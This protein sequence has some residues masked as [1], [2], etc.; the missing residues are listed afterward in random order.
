MTYWG[1]VEHQTE[2]KMSRN[3]SH[4]FVVHVRQGLGRTFAQQ[5]GKR[6]RA[7]T[8]VLC[9]KE[10]DFPR[11]LDP[12]ET[13]A[14]KTRWRNLCTRLFFPFTTLWGDINSVSKNLL[15]L[16]TDLPAAGSHSTHVVVCAKD[17]LDETTKLNWTSARTRFANCNH[18][19]RSP[20]GS[21]QYF[22]DAGT[23]SRS[24]DETLSLMSN[25]KP[26]NVDSE[27]DE[28]SF[29]AA[30]S[31]CIV[32]AGPFCRSGLGV[33]LLWWNIQMLLSIGLHVYW[34]R[35]ALF[36]VQKGPQLIERSWVF[37]LL[38][39]DVVQWSKDVRVGLCTNLHI[40]VVERLSWKNERS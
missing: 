19:S 3:K 30:A 6:S 10:A 14:A 4:L 5:K 20:V 27:S 36:Y 2:I 11:P 24:V 39:F 22:T 23:W 13:S 16:S 33:L 15:F 18:D 25:T 21:W 28:R 12:L 31:P 17:A 35:Y 38:C 34:I 32:H 26:H 29:I 40:S 8:E 9:R 1:Q 7:T 37:D